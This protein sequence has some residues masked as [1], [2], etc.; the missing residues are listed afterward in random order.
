MLYTN[1]CLGSQTVLFTS[2]MQRIKKKQN[3]EKDEGEVKKKKLSSFLYTL[4]LALFID[5]ALYLKIRPELLCS[6]RQV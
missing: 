1:D 6:L 5:C 3:D 2:D 4:A